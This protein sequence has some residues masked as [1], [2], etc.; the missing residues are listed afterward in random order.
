M[1][2]SVESGPRVWVGCLACYNAGRLRGKW[3]TAE[4]MA[5]EID[6]ERVTFLGLGEP[7]DRGTLCVVCGGDEWDVMD[8]EDVP[9]VC[10]GLRGFMDHASDLVQMDDGTL[11]RVHVLAVALGGD[12][13]LDDLLAYDQDNYQGQWDRFRDFAEHYA[14]EVGDVDAMPEHLRDYLDYDAYARTLEYDY[15]HDDA[16]GHIWRS[17]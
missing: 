8:S 5:E 12:M 16:T 17:V 13:S 10:D 14:E 3:I 11:E 9:R 15:F 7:S 4:R 6:A 1:D 2:I